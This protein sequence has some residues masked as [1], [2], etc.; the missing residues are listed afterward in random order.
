MAQIATA[1]RSVTPN[2]TDF[3]G[4]KTYLTTGYK[5]DHFRYKMFISQPR[6]TKAEIATQKTVMSVRTTMK[7]HMKSLSQC[8]RFKGGVLIN[9]LPDDMM[10]DPATTAFTNFAD[11]KGLEVINLRTSGHANAVALRL[12]ID[13]VHP[14]K[15]LPMKRNTNFWMKTEYPNTTIIAVDTIEL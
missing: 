4:V 15:T 7:K 12:L 8:M 9:A 13:T 1:T 3:V 2:S 5:E 14:V 10:N 11:E 6:I